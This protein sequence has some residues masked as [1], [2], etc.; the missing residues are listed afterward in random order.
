MS[1]IPLE[2]ISTLETGDFPKKSQVFTPFFI[3]ILLR[4]RIDKRIYT[5]SGFLS[6]LILRNTE[7]I[8]GK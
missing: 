3:S 4:I 1:E 5:N 7:L 6:L 2:K 8:N